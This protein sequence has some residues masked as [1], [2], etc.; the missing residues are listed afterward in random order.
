MILERKHLLAAA[1]LMVAAGQ[2]VAQAKERE[3][4]DARATYVGGGRYLCKG[5]SVDCALIK[6]NNRRITRETIERGKSRGRSD[7]K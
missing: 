3:T 5:S 4:K 1:I 6:E 2:A 7:K